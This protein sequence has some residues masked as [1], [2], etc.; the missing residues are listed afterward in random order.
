M[1]WNV[2]VFALL[3]FRIVSVYTSTAVPLLCWIEDN[4]SE[5]R[6]LSPHQPKAG[7]SHTRHRHNTE[8]NT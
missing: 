7:Y 1:R 5:R 4:H 2:I 3:A 8:D 6:A